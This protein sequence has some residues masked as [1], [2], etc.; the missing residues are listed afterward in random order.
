MHHVAGNFEAFALALDESADV[1]DIAQLCI[2]VRGIDTRFNITEDL[3][4][5]RS[6]RGTCKGDDIFCECNSALTEADLF[7]EKL[8]GVAT[9]GARA[10]IGNQKGFQGC[11]IK[12][13]N[14]KSSRNYLVSLY[15]LPRI[16]VC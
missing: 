1:S 5:L 10:I 16:F 13:R 6:M 14:Q 3:L 15:N 9:D 8:L 11:L 12:V 4:S 2:F 7:Y